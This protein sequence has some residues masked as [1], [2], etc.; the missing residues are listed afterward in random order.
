MLCLNVLKL[1]LSSLQV[2]NFTVPC[3]TSL[4]KLVLIELDKKNIPLFPEDAWFPD[5]V[6]VRSPEAETYHFPIY[7]WIADNQVHR[8]REGKGLWKCLCL[9]TCMLFTDHRRHIRKSI[10]RLEQIHANKLYI[11][12]VLKPCCCCCFSFKL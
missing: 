10:W 7:R 2:S 8:F 4:G 5:K 1:F 12:I 9:T 11:S 3:P 6:T